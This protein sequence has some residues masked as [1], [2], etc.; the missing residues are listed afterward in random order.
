MALYED[1][2]ME[3][4]EWMDE[5][6]QLIIGIDASEDVHT[7][8]M[9]EFFQTLGLRNAILDK[10][11][12]SSPPATNNRNNQRQ[13][14][15][16]LF[17]TPDL[18]AVPAR[19][20]AFGAGCPSDH[21]VLWADFTYTDAFVLSSTPLVSPGV[22]R[23]NT[24]NPRLVEKY[25]QQLRKQLVHSGLAK[26]LFSLELCATQRGWSSSLQD[27]YDDIQ[28]AHLKLCRQIELKLRKLRM[29][30]IPWSPKLQGFRNAIEFGQ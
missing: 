26:R 1:L 9:A 3:C 7:G 2:F 27:D 16:G 28:A 22:R 29:G 18:R 20:S 30:G 13:P 10:H 12:Q 4:T 5:G 24:K 19:Y 14:I 11:S 21:C 25:V 6:D 15:D 23:L 8:A 17:V